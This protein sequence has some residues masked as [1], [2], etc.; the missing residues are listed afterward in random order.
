MKKILDKLI[1]GGI[2]SGS[3]AHDSMIGMALGKYPAVQVAAF[4]TI[5][6]MRR[7]TTDELKAFR[8]AFLEL[9]KKPNLGTLNAID[10]CG[11]GGDRK[12]TFNISTLSSLIVA[13]AGYP[14][15]KH[16]A[17]SAS[18]SFGSSDIMT[19]VGYK[20]TDNEDILKRQLEE[21]NF[22]YLHSPFYYG[23]MKNISPIRKD[24]GIQNFFNIIGPIVNPVQPKFQ[25]VGVYSLTV[26]ELYHQ[27]L[28][29]ERDNFTIVH[30]SDVFDEISLT[31]D[32]HAIT[33]SEA[34]L[35]EPESIGFNRI[36]PKRLLCAQTPEE[37]AKQFIDILENKGTSEQTD[38]VV[39]NAA[40]AINTINGQN[41]FHKAVEEARQA[42]VSGKAR[43]VLEKLRNY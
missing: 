41:N 7:I 38:V 11:T 31:A 29:E 33:R 43:A 23:F 27:I 5:F 15:I 17:G 26:A 34:D 36:S 2:L 24:L 12:N 16:G 40:A 25:L 35:I 10:S 8:N 37:K 4:L 22:C 9:G 14:V 39:V 21:T 30:S 42:L 18:G 28:S 13:G 19:A 3:E 20:L 32:F 1:A 6:E